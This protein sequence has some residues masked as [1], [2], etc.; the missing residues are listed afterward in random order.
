MKKTKETSTKLCQTALKGEQKQQLD[1]KSE[2]L[3]E[4]KDTVSVEDLFEKDITYRDLPDAVKEYFQLFLNRLPKTVGIQKSQ[5]EIILRMKNILMT[6]YLRDII[7]D[8]IVKVKEKYKDSDNPE[9]WA[10]QVNPTLFTKFK[11]MRDSLSSEIIELFDTTGLD[12]DFDKI[13]KVTLSRITK[14]RKL[15]KDKEPD[16]EI[17]DAEYEVLNDSK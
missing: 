6:G 15:I 3:I 14:E 17:V 11:Q 12:E 9:E 8:H 5:M 1:L 10:R 7:F 13:E 4:K 16:G 2:H